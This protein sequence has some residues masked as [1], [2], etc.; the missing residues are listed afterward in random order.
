MYHSGCTYGT[1]TGY[2]SMARIESIQS[3][4]ALSIGL[5]MRYDCFNV[6]SH[7]FS[8]LNYCMIERE[9]MGAYDDEPLPIFFESGP[10]ISDFTV[11]W[12]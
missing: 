6:P 11:V 5:W 1:I 4:F 8:S 9:N 3:D 7:I 2:E 10:Y 12:I